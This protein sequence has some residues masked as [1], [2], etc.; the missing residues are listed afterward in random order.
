MS[1][2]NAIQNKFNNCSV[3][4]IEACISKESQYIEWKKRG[5]AIFISVDCFAEKCKMSGYRCDEIIFHEEKSGAGKSLYIY[6]IE[7][8]SKARNRRKAIEQ[9]QASATYMEKHIKRDEYKYHIPV[10]A[11]SA[12][13]H[14]QR[15]KQP[16]IEM[17]GKHQHIKIE[18]RN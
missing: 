8:K 6:L 13:L 5:K 1:S 3:V 16:S 10:I 15:R 11:Y 14:S 2:I 12:K 18:K 17:H 7:A 9:L 4:G